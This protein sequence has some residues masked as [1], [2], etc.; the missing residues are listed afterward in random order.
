MRRWTQHQRRLVLFAYLYEA[1]SMCSLS[2]YPRPEVQ[3]VSID[4]IHAKLKSKE[5]LLAFEHDRPEGASLPRVGLT[6][7]AALSLIL[8]YA[9]SL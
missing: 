7:V 8:C 3:M 4:N 2:S 5:V 9:Y 6:A 1:D